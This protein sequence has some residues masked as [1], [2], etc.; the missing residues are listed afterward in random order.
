MRELRELLRGRGLLFGGRVRDAV[1]TGV[2]HAEQTIA[3]RSG[4]GAD[5]MAV[6]ALD[7]HGTLDQKSLE[8]HA[9]AMRTA[10]FRKAGNHRRGVM[11]RL[12]LDIVLRKSSDYNI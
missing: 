8:E 6:L 5:G 2:Y 9:M 1:R 10:I 4:N 3:P 11:H 12:L 7:L